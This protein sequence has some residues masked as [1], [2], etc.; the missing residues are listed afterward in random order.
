MNT[1]Q[2]LTLIIRRECLLTWRRPAE[3][4]NPLLFFILV[5][6]LFPLSMTPDLKILQFIGPGILWVAVILAVLLSLTRLF[7]PD[8]DDGSLEQWLFSP[9][10][11][12]LLIFAKITA[13]W[14]MLCIPLMV[15]MPILALMFHLS[16]AVIGVLFITLLLGTPLLILLG[17]IGSALTVSLRHSGLLLALIILPLY[18]PTLIFATSA[19]N[20]ASFGQPVAAPLAWLGA[21]LALALV[22][23]PIV[24]AF[25]LRIGLSY[26]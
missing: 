1:I 17:A 13:H 15:L 6:M 20:A 11:L 8:Y 23:A 9:Q 25:S 26:R 4:L 18:I 7:Q 3:W 19:I 21:L 12:P 24:T 16:A 2:S 22:L 5:A 14:L 10:P